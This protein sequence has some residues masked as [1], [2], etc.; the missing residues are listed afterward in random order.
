[1][2]RTPCNEKISLLWGWDDRV[3][4]QAGRS[5]LVIIWF[6]GLLFVFADIIKA[7][8]VAHCDVFNI[9]ELCR[10]WRMGPPEE[11]ECSSQKGISSWKTKS[12]SITKQIQ[13]LYQNSVSRTLKI[14]DWLLRIRQPRVFVIYISKREN[15]INKYTIRQGFSY[16]RPKDLPPNFDVVIEWWQYVIIWFNWASKISTEYLVRLCQLKCYSVRTRIDS[17]FY[18][19]MPHT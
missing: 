2:W 7:V 3:D 18:I 19:S 12:S 6:F 15:L 16:F 11:K 4:Q 10:W 17:F 14:Q 1:M 5:L 13:D 9:H 8:C